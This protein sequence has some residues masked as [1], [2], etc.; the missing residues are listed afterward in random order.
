MAA[1]IAYLSIQTRHI[2][3]PTGNAVSY[4]TMSLHS[5][6]TGSFTVKVVPRPGSLATTISP[7]RFLMMFIR[8]FFIG[9]GQLDRPLS[10]P[11]FKNLIGFINPPDDF[12][13]Q[14]DDQVDKKSAPQKNKA[15]QQFQ[16]KMTTGELQIQIYAV[17]GQKE[18]HQTGQEAPPAGKIMGIALLFPKFREIEA[19][20]KIAPTATKIMCGMEVMVISDYKRTAMPMSPRKF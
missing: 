8:E 17:A 6:T 13:G 1:L 11:F 4:L 15:G 16:G 9:C 12:H 5:V 14:T 19:A 3:L 10:D 18:N 2:L 7:S 20:R